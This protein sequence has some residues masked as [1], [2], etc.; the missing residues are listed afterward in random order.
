MI[1]SPSIFKNAKLTTDSKCLLSS[2]WVHLLLYNWIKYI[3]VKSKQPA[4][5]VRWDEKA[6]LHSVLVRC[7]CASYNT[8]RILSMLRRKSKG[9]STVQQGRY[10]RH[11][12]NRGWRWWGRAS[13]LW[14]VPSNSDWLTPAPSSPLYHDHPLPSSKYNHTRI[15]FTHLCTRKTFCF[16][17]INVL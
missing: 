7:C 1:Q 15:L 5:S 11:C 17:C 13:R 10:H 3:F 8:T 2:F 9:A 14:D 6:V 16:P 4:L 12:T